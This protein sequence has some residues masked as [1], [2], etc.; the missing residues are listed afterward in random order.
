LSSTEHP[1]ACL[2]PELVPLTGRQKLAASALACWFVGTA[3]LMAVPWPSVRPRIQRILKPT[4]PLLY[5]IGIH[6]QLVLFSPDPPR[7]TGKLLFRVRY[8]D[9]TQGEWTYPRSRLAPL[10]PPRAFDRYL[11]YY[12]VWSFAQTAL[13]LQPYLAHYIAE[14]S[15][16]PGKQP[17][18]VEMVERYSRLA[19]ARQGVGKPVPQPD[20]EMVFFRYDVAS[21]RATVSGHPYAW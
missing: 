15:Y 8:A 4:L 18:T 3:L 5:N 2:P 6:H 20:R 16:A 12:T 1:Q 11:F 19:P 14:D 21:H 10:D 17:V 9:G 13:T 7:M